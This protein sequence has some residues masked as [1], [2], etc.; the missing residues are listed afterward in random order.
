MHTLTHKRNI[1]CLIDRR[2]HDISVSKPYVCL[3]V[4]S[5]GAVPKGL[6]LRIFLCLMFAYVLY[7][8]VSG[9]ILWILENLWFDD[10]CAE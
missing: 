1:D 8:F 3:F 4:C 10:L 9:L 7:E 2:V 5:I 6:I